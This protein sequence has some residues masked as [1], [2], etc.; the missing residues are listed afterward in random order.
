[1]TAAESGVKAL[2]LAEQQKF[3]LVLLDVRMPVMD[4]YETVKRLRRLAGY[5][6]VPVIAL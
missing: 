4:G 1:M 3:S 6:K 2:Q 5:E